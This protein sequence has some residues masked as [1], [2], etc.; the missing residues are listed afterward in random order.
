M[1]IFNLKM[2]MKD[3]GIGNKTLSEKS[4]VPLGTLNKIIYGDTANPTLDNM[5]AIADAL[6][7]TLDDFVR[8][9]KDLFVESMPS[10][11]N[12]FYKMYAALDKHGKEVVDFLL[13]KEFER[14][15][16]SRFDDE[17]DVDAALEKIN[18]NNKDSIAE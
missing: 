17:P 6:G 13:Q 5:R 16:A 2:I 8:D 4:G 15:S 12:S 9:P 3:R 14:C 11:S 7:C 1:T 18:K 10:D